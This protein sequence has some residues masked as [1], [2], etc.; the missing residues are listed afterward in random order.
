MREISTLS[1]AWICSNDI[2]ISS[3]MA[4]ATLIV[5]VRPIPVALLLAVTCLAAVL[6]YRLFFAPLSKIPGPKLT[7]VTQ[8]WVMYH[9]FKGDRTVQI[10]ELHS[11]YGPVVRVSPDEVSFNNYEG[12]REIYGIKSTFSKS[13]FYDLFVYYNERNTFTSLDKPNVRPLP[14]PSSLISVLI[15]DNLALGQEKAGRRSIHQEL[16]DAAV[17][18]RQSTRACFGIHEAS[19]NSR[20]RSRRLH[21]ATLLCTRVCT[22]PPPI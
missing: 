19:V 13:S 11:R 5:G 3:R 18:G 14:S 9:E 4:I 15:L 8:L 22:T 10:D 1:E 21:L 7:A 20:T 17:R 12:L 6:I 2:Y 16:R